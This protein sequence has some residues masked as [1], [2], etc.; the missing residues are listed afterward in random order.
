MEPPPN[1]TRTL[2]LDDGSKVEVVE[3]FSKVIED[4]TQMIE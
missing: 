4:G 3:G 2:E 1:N